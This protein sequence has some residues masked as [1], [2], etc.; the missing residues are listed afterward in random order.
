MGKTELLGGGSLAERGSYARIRH[1]RYVGSFLAIL[2]ACF[3]AGKSAMWI[4]AGVWTGLTLVAISF[5]ERELR[6]RFG[7]EY[8]DYARRVP[9]FLPRLR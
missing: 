9:R 3:L 4:V 8:E 7:A 6:S 5:E 2:G 1:P